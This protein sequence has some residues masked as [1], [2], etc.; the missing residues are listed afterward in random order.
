[1]APDDGGWHT[2]GPGTGA[3]DG[4]EA[5]SAMTEEQ[6][7]G[8]IADFAAAAVR[9]V[10][11]GFD[12][13]EIHGAHGYLLHQ[14]QSPLVNDRTDRWG[15]DETGRNRLTLAVVDAVRNV[16]PDSMPLLLQDLGLRL[17]RGRHRRRVLGAD[18]QGG[19][20]PRRGPRGRFQRRRR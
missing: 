16:I 3:F 1:M 11:A 4:Y 19:L 6:I 5:P 8:V 9:A 20:G 13:I 10:G 2:V 15:G 14:F 17:G 7:D 12:T 18:G